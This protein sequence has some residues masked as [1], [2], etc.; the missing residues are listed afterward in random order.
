MD[1]ER[2]NGS[3]FV[4]LVFISAAWSLEPG[5][6]A[7]RGGAA[8]DPPVEPASKVGSEAPHSGDVPAPEPAAAE[9]PP[10][11]IV[12]GQIT[13]SIGAGQKDVVLALHRKADDGSR[14]EA[15]ATTTTDA[16][17]DFK[18]TAK[19]RLS[20]SFLVAMTKPSFTELVR[21]LELK[22]DGLPLYVAETLQGSLALSGR[23]ESAA[24]RRPVAGAD[25]ELTAVYQRWQSASGSDGRFRI[26]GIPPGRGELIVTAGGFGRERRR[27]ANLAEPGELVIAL[28][29]ERVVRISV[30][31]DAGR[32]V[33]GA[34]LEVADE[35]RG[36]FRSALTDANGEAEF[37]G[38]HFETRDLL[39]RLAHEDHVSS[40]GFDR[41]LELPA[42]QPES[43]HDLVM[44]RAAKVSGLVKVAR[45][46]RPLYGARVMIGSDAADDSPRDWT[47]QEGRFEIHGV[48][49]GDT[50]VTVHM[51]GFA[52]ELQTVTTHSG[53]ASQLVV[54]LSPGATVSGTVV[55]AEDQPIEGAEVAAIKWRGHSTLGLRAMTDQAGKFVIE[56]APPD[57]FEVEVYAHRHKPREQSLSAAA[58]P[59]RIKLEGRPEQA[60][61]VALKT[62]QDA[63]AVKLVALGGQ[64][65]DLAAQKGK[66]V[67][68]DFWAT[69]CAPCLEELPDLIDIYEKYRGRKDFVLIG[70]SRDFSEADLRRFLEKNPR[71][72]WA[73]VV[74]ADSGADEAAE[75][76]GIAGIPTLVVLD[77]E[78]RVVAPEVRTDGLPAHLESLFKSAETG[79]P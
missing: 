38:M 23:I 34:E 65:I 29:P 52:P 57:E 76:F 22:P 5:L 53:E 66:V 8:F 33:M 73:Q 44:Q 64:P 77:R 24:G 72:A 13:D 12:E 20:G 25:L 40:Q 17:G 2:F 50:I 58:A 11:V 48:A 26:E 27:I 59:V 9:E 61:P 67:V 51:A 30:L 28:T 4:K 69:W 68:L 46:E 32:P 56:S 18:I 14:G 54:E 37:R 31:D 71:M 62:G 78:G 75:K 6:A 49:P 36:D 45:E 63:P 79:S 35:A 47:D 15:I 3:M 16:M 1:R 10:V 19:E 70:V 55:D 74:G 21:D 42:D 41:K 7:A 39:A 60:A 43:K